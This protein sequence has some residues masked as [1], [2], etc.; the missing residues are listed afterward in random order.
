MSTQTLAPT[1]GTGATDTVVPESSGNKYASSSPASETVA[2]GISY[3]FVPTNLAGHSFSSLVDLRGQVALREQ[4]VGE[5]QSSASQNAAVQGPYERFY[6]TIKDL[7]EQLLSAGHST[8]IRQSKLDVDYLRLS[9]SLKS[10]EALS[11][12]TE[13]PFARKVLEEAHHSAQKM[14]GLAHLDIVSSAQGSLIY[15]TKLELVN[16]RLAND[17]AANSILKQTV[18][19]ASKELRSYIVNSIQSLVGGKI[20]NSLLEKFVTPLT[21]SADRQYQAALTFD[22]EQQAKAVEE[23]NK[24]NPG[25]LGR[26]LEWFGSFPM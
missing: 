1:G 24:T 12:L 17:P 10:V 26:I 7:R 19:E 6:T 5:T 8:E 15:F 21:W 20:N 25:L 13:D 11:S 9:S 2:T 18:N 14:H 16:Q 3:E 22:K 4:A 23:S